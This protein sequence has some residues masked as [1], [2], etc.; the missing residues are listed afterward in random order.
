VHCVKKWV[1][2]ISAFLDN[3]K[4]NRKEDR[5]LILREITILV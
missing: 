1:C 3:I 4:S 5:K 2:V